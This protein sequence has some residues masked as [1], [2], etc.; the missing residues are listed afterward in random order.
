[1]T[2]GGKRNLLPLLLLL[3]T[4]L[5]SPFEV[6]ALSYDYTA[7]IECLENPHKPQYGGGIIVNPELNHGLRGWFTFGDAKL[8][9]RESET[10]NKFAVASNRNQPH[11]G[12]S[13]KTHLQRNKLYT[14]SAW[15]RVSGGR[16]VPVTAIF[17]TSAGSFIH[18][19]SIVAESS[20]WSMLKGG[21]TVNASGPAEL[22]FESKNT[23]VDIL[24]DS[25]SL[26]PFTE[27][28]WKS[29]HDQSIEKNRKSNVRIQ[30]VD[31]QGNPLRNAKISIQQKASSFPFGCAMNK[32]ILTKTAYQNWF[33]S[34]FGVTT[35]EDEMKWY[36]TENSQGK[37]DYS[38]ADAMLQFAK[39]QNIAV[40]GHNVFWDDPQYQL[41]WVKSLDK[42]QLALAAFRRLYSVMNRYKGQVIAWDVVNENLHFKF[43]E[44]KLGANA[45]AIFYNRAS[46]ADETT[47]LF[48]NEFNTI[49]ESGDGDSIPPKYL[50]KLR[51]IQAFPGNNNLR[52]AIGLESHFRSPNIPYIR[53]SIDTLAAANLPIWITELDVQSG[54]NQ[55]WYL[56]QILR[57][58]YTHPKIEGIV[59][60]SAWRPE[61]CY[62]MCLTDNNFKN[63]PT[64][65]VV[66]KLLS[67][68]GLKA[69]FTSSATTD[70]NGVFETSLPHGDYEVQISDPKSVKVVQGL[71]VAASSTASQ[72]LL[73]VQLAA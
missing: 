11:A 72:Q 8:Q 50:Q 1:M 35:F 13:Q 56:E 30:A 67:E 70:A 57:E 45:S 69:G 54:P 26:Q 25:V 5:F 38:V 44:S 66:D 36:S 16:G 2:T 47:T 71:N 31:V 4:L 40:R 34:R 9:H 6:N 15:I 52:M 43:F 28:E 62:R 63:L 14:F 65:D 22:N 10:G 46:K 60:W 29:H 55:A 39:Q 24:V 21:L 53:S 7:S 17:K 42:R 23:S 33:T 49:E 59:I 48:M 37:E 58:V 32:N 64:G 73:L 51:D 19:G 68:W 61:G 41:G 18:A 27:K 3:S 12:I 20:C